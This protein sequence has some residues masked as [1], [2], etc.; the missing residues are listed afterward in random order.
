MH[1]P[2]N[3]VGTGEEGHV[4][5]PASNAERVEF[6]IKGSQEWVNTSTATWPWSWYV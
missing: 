3:D 4:P 5:V 6:L 1:S 2:E